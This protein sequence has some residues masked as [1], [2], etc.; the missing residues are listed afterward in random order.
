MIIHEESVHNDFSAEI[1][2]TITIFESDDSSR[3][4]KIF[5]GASYEFLADKYN[6]SLNKI[7]DDML[8]DWKSYIIKKYSNFGESTLLKEKIYIDTYSMSENGWKN[9]HNF[10]VNK[11][12]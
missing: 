6:T 1:Y 4:S 5:S 9:V 11:S 3:Y 8:K 10:L 7:T 2:W 12:G